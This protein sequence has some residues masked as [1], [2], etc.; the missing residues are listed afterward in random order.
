MKKL[1]IFAVIAAVI[2]AAIVF[3]RKHALFVGDVERDE[4][5]RVSGVNIKS[6]KW[7]ERQENRN[8]RI[9]ERVGDGYEDIY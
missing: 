8:A 6:G 2:I 3:F 5:G 7:L 9:T 1:V 4:H